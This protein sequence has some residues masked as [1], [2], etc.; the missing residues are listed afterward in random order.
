MHDINKQAWIVLDDSLCDCAECAPDPGPVT[1]YEG[2]GEDD[3]PVIWVHLSLYDAPHPLL[4]R[5]G[6]KHR[7][8]VRSVIK[9][10]YWIM[11]HCLTCEFE[12]LR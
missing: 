7:S 11:L 2:L 5:L 1:V 10:V 8:K 9:S 12:T 6:N 3:A 4:Y